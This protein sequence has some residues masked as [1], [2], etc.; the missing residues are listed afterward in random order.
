MYLEILLPIP[1]LINNFLHTKIEAPCH[2]LRLTPIP[3][4]LLNV[5][6]LHHHPEAMS[7][8]PILTA[9]CILGICLQV[10]RV[11]GCVYGAI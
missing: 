9:L 4:H 3:Q 1:L 10:A 7:H 5:T 2:H 8:S 6:F 11:S